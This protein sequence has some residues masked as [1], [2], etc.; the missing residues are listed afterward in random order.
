MTIG[1]EKLAASPRLSIEARLAPVQGTRFQPTGF[2]DLGAATYT[3]HDGTAMCL[4]ESAQ[5][6]A[7]RLEA[8]CWDEARNDLATSLSGLPYVKVLDN[9]GVF[10]TSS[11]LES[12]RISSPYILDSDDTTFFDLLKTQVEV[13]PDRPIDVKGLASFLFKYDPNSLLHG[14]F[15]A[16]SAIAG[17]RY[18]VPRALSAFIEA[19][20]VT[21]VASGGVKFDNVNPQGD[22]KQRFGH[23]P[24]HRDEYAAGAITAS[25]IID[26]EQVRSYGLKDE[27]RE[28]LVALALYK[29][30]R[31]LDAG[32]RLR[33]ACDLDVKEVTVTR[34]VGFALPAADELE[35]TVRA[36]ITRVAGN[37][38]FAGVTTISFTPPPP[39][40]DKKKASEGT[41]PEESGA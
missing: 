15:I 31:F 39:K 28:L 20:D 35:Q 32:L 17:G 18:K 25:F 4:V 38:G 2:P 13:Q 21:I 24:F 36:L 40:K 26:L 5:S 12:H 9:K 3:L 29:V 37:K 41:A 14:V 33:T 8:V 7:N 6:M 11:I 30:R 10:L 23:I 27:E 16:N 22:A 34:P 19:R 1:L